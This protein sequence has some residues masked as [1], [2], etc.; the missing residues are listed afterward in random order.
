MSYPKV[1]S[2]VVVALIL[3]WFSWPPEATAYSSQL[4]AGS[5]VCEITPQ[6]GDP[7]SGYGARNNRPAIGIR[8]R[9]FVRSLVLEGNGLR[10]ALVS[11]DILAFTPSLRASI[12]ERTKDVGLDH[13]LLAATHTHS[14]PGGYQ[15]GWA[16]GRFL[17]GTYREEVFEQL[18][19]T[20]ADCIR[21]ARQELVPAH[22]SYGTGSA[23]E[24][25]RNRRSD[26]GMSDATVGVVSIEK[27][28]GGTI[29]LIVNFG[30]H[31]TVLS[32]E[33][34]FYSGDYAGAAE[35]TLEQWVTA[36]V[37]FFAGALGD[38]KPHYPGTKEWEA[39]LREQFEEADV[40]GHTL[41]VEVMRTRA[42]L[43]KEPLSILGV[44]ERRVTL[45]PVNVRD[46]CFYYVLTPVARVLFRGIFHPETIFQVVRINDLFVLGMPAE[47]SSEIVLRIREALAGRTVLAVS[48]ANDSLGYVLTP[49]DYARGGYEAC[50]S[51]YGTQFGAF[52]EQH[53]LAT[54]YELW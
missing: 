36:P 41:A 49:A 54:V 39:P 32:P 53:A 12:L 19:S 8:D 5:A 24:L 40:I 29:A 26:S 20:I 48:L 52:F 28:Q 15:K 3:L 30:A 1:C 7:M 31:P 42:A 10:V 9:L 34:R 13:I 37:L 44:R 11:A 47:V 2:V 22:I 46:S 17:M 4:F 18:S 43:R 35:R 6:P 21:K 50:M 45:P 27:E 51:F 16:I 25:V 23:P 14:G 38:Q 33:N